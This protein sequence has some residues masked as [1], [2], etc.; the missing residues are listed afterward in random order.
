MSQPKQKTCLS[1][2]ELEKY[3]N[4]HISEHEEADLQQHIGGCTHCQEQLEQL[5]ASRAMWDGLRDSIPSDSATTEVVD[6]TVNNLIDHLAPTEDPKFLGRLGA[7]EVC[8]II[9]QGST[10]IVLKAFEPRL[11]RYVAIKVLSPTLASNGSARKRFEREGRAIA[12]VSHEHV[13]PIYAVD[14]YRGLPYIVMQ[15]IPGVSLLQRIKKSGSLNTCEVVRIGLQVARGLDAAHR[16]GI[17]HRDVKPANVILEDTIDRA[18][19][20]DFG[21]ARVADEGTMTRTGTISGTP[22]YM[23][24]EQARGEFIDART[25]LFSLGSLMYTACTARP[26]FRAETVFGIIHRVCETEPRTIQEINPDIA[27]WLVQFIR[28]LMAKEPN[29]RFESAAQVAELLECELAHL[30]NPSSSQVPNREWLRTLAPERRIE[31]SNWSAR[32]LATAAI[33]AATIFGGYIAW[34]NFDPQFFAIAAGEKE[35]NPDSASDPTKPDDPDIALSATSPS[36]RGARN[37]ASSANTPNPSVNTQVATTNSP[38]DPTSG[39]TENDANATTINVVSTTSP[40]E[41]P[42]VIWERINDSSNALQQTFVQR[43]DQSFAIETDAT[44]SL[45]A[46]HGDIEVQQTELDYASFVIISH[47]NAANRAEAE[48]IATYHQ[49]TSQSDDGVTIETS[50]DES[51]KERG[52]KDRFDRIVYGLAVP[53]GTHVNVNAKDGRILVGSLTGNVS[54]VAKSGDVRFGK[55]RG[56]IWARS[57][58]GEIVANQGCTGDAD[59]FATHGNICA[60]GIEQKGR[61]RSSDGNIYVGENPGK[62]YAHS[63]GGDVRIASIK[64]PISGHVEVGDLHLLATAPPESDCDLSVNS[65]DIH[66]K[67]PEDSAVSINARGEIESVVESEWRSDS[68]ADDNS[69]T[70]ANFWRKL[71]L[72]PGGPTMTLAASTGK[73]VL[74]TEPAIEKKKF[75]WRKR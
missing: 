35:N 25:D 73:I 68:T 65:G 39:N 2:T 41:A 42:K 18:M 15:Y 36:E 31:K 53:V 75:S 70:A 50:L 11:N 56:D 21:L 47:I 61:L 58:G 46:E 6:T 16:Q 7:Y 5:A 17:V 8:G 44:I 71:T 19:V 3:L 72:K 22:Q 12:S 4:E 1:R 57:T 54:A 34:Q 37:N 60:A 59:C 45:T 33:F 40:G 32:Y 20:T 62:I 38:K 28:K 27:P 48:K 10:G 64:G 66:V 23:S 51:F 24:P 69:D 74:D 67:L 13:V 52:G 30:Q 55:I 14:D 9:G 49:A 26:P 43:V 29:D 63:T